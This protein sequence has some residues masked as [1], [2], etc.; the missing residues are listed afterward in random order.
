MKRHVELV[1]P[2]ETMELGQE[3]WSEMFADKCNE[4]ADLKERMRTASALIAS[5]AVY[6]TCGDTETALVYQK[7]LEDLLCV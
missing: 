4:V 3:L 1:D 6:M 2:E 5:Y 7:R